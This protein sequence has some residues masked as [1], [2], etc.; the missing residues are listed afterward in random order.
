MAHKV[1]A[2]LRPKAHRAML[3]AL[4]RGPA[5]IS[6]ADLDAA[7]AVL[8][9]SLGGPLAAA[10][11]GVR[12]PGGGVVLTARRLVLAAGH[13]R[14]E[15]PVGQEVIAKACADGSPTLVAYLM[16]LLSTGRGAGAVADLA[17]TV[18]PHA[19]EVSWLHRHLGVLDG[20][21][22]PAE[23]IDDDGAELRLRQ[24]SPVT[25]GPT[26]VILL[27]TLLDPAYALWLTTGVHIE[28]D[29]P[30][31]FL[32]FSQRFRSQQQLVHE[33]LTRH[34]LGPMAWPRMLGSPPWALAG[35]LNR[36]T[37]LA[38]ASCAWIMVDP[39]DSAL[40]QRCLDAAAAGVRAGIPVPI[41]LGRHVDRHVVLAIAA[42]GTGLRIYDPASGMVLD[43]DGADIIGGR[44]GV[45]GWDTLEGVIVPVVSEGVWR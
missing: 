2:G 42:T 29:R 31:D 1:R 5:P 27:R 26:S 30:A 34:A 16:A 22:G 39:A 11:S 20:A 18:S 35:F 28:A 38:G 23:F 40:V 45:A 14:A 13:L 36:F 7:L 4:D 10:L 8:A 41:Y 15:D 17:S 6:E 3:A 19:R 37:G 21:P 25:C 32:P 12:R 33:S 44:I 43:V 9:E 24:L